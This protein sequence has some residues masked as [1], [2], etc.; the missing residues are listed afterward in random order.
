MTSAKIFLG[1]QRV[2]MR[3]RRLGRGD[4]HRFTFPVSVKGKWA[5]CGVLHGIEGEKGVIKLFSFG[6]SPWVFGSSGK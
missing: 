6:L 5:V 4:D 3:R 2:S 1:L